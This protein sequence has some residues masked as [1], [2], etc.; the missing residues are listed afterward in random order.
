MLI[1]YTE[2]FLVLLID[3]SYSSLFSTFLFDSNFE[4]RDLAGQSQLVSAWDF[5]ATIRMWPGGGLS[6]VLH[7]AQGKKRL[8]KKGGEIFGSWNLQGVSFHFLLRDGFMRELFTCHGL[9]KTPTFE[10]FLYQVAVAKQY[11][12]GPGT[13]L[14]VERSVF[15][16]VMIFW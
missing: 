4:M 7:I 10:T 12:T 2:Q 8:C 9:F 15:Q 11:H 5:I 16:C 1:E 14:F 6:G 3:S 13:C